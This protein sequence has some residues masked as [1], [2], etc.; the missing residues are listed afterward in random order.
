MVAAATWRLL[1]L[2]ASYL[3]V[4]AALY[5]LLCVLLLATVPRDLPGPGIGPANRV[6]LLRAI[7]VMAVTGLMAYPGPLGDAV[8]WWV[9]GLSTVA[10]VLDGFDGWMARRTGTATGFG[11]RFD[12]EL[13]A[14]LM[15]VLSALVWESGKVGPWVVLIGLLRYLFVAGG[16]VWTALQGEL[17]VS[18]RRK[19]V[20]VIQGVVLLV[21]LG[22]VIPDAAAA[23]LAAV[24]LASLLYSFGVDVWWLL[25]TEGRRAG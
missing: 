25:E 18:L 5:G 12:M 13:D 20:C 22:P 3:A 10:M 23:G 16:L 7:L 1:S 21:A 8:L 4:V 15:L 6:T 11:A 17:P 14:F 19:T 24:A 2:P 9:I